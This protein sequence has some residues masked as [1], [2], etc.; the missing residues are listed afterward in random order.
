MDAPLNPNM[1][2]ALNI[3]E[4]SDRTKISIPLNNQP[5]FTPRKL[6]AIIIGAG[7]SSLTLVHKLRH[8]HPEMEDIL[9]YKIFEARS[10]IGGTWLVNTYPGVQCDVPAHIYAFPFDPNPSWSKFYVG[11][12]E[13]HDY[14]KRTVMKWNLD[15]DVQLNTK[16]IGTYW[17]EQQGLWKVVV[18]H[19]GVQ[20][21]EYA[22]ILISGQ[23]FLNLWKWPVIK[24]L[25]SF[26]GKKV[27]SAEWDHLYDY[28]DKRIAVIGNGS[29]GIQILPQLAKLEGTDVTSIQRGPTWVI[30]RMSAAKLLGRDDISPNPEY[31]EDDKR[32]F[33]EDPKYHNEYRKQLIHRINRAFR[34]FVKGSPANLEA[35]EFA[36][37]QMSNKLGNDPELC[38]KLIPD[39]E[40]GCRRI[41][42]GEGYLESFLRPNVH[43]TQSPIT[44]V[45]EHAIHT[46][47]GQVVEVDVIVC[48]TG[49]D[50]S[51]CPHYPVIG[52][53]QTSLAEKWAEE[54]ESYLSLACPQ[55]PNYFIFT[56]PNAVVG[57]GSL[58]EGLGWVAEYMIKWIKKISTED[59]KAVAPKQEVVDEFVTYGD[60]IQ[61]T[62]TWTGGCRSWYKKG[63]VDG[64][65]TAA[66]A[67]SALLFKRFVSEIRGE[68]F[69]IQ[70]RSPNRF[71]MMGNGFTEYELDDANDLAWYIEK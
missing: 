2:T 63:R 43:L 15:R 47:D 68:D 66:F 71:K 46:A 59:I 3:G 11:G 38:R 10:D 41:T 7:Y 69:E 65:V 35:T 67:G 34:M 14:I 20:R 51:H 17:Q 27:H 62:L 53:D 13:I 16:V 9:T 48:A 30:S 33:T 26:K 44:H 29:S 21:E 12:P 50:V 70:Y 31:T 32:R 5:S 18:E 45:T 37:K 6:R 54:P 42:P 58:V 60:E 49:F 28:S 39:W 55:F 57:H 61:K 19:N 40:L 52:R 22:E 56:G 64:R 23:G 4:V 36:K 1:H 25:E 8:Q 24:G